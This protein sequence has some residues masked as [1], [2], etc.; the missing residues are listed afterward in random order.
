MHFFY[1]ATNP[2]HPQPSPPPKSK[3]TREDSQVVAY[4]H[5]GHSQCCLHPAQAAKAHTHKHVT[6]KTE[7]PSTVV[8]HTVENLC[9]EAEISVQIK[10]IRVQTFSINLQ[11]FNKSNIFS[12]NLQTDES[13]LLLNSLVIARLVHLEKRKLYM[14]SRQKACLHFTTMSWNN[15]ILCGWRD[16][17]LQEPGTA[18]LISVSS[19]SKVW[20]IIWTK[21]CREHQSGTCMWNLHTFLAQN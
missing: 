4:K 2:P 6:L 11:T 15:L 5:E 14:S 8:E 7:V 13:F 21:D 12:I 16:I 9:W 18:R 10:Q 20:H 17:R 19:S 3:N 1:S